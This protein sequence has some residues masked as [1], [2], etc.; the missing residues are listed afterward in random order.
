MAPTMLL[1]MESL[2]SLYDALVSINIPTD[3][4]RAVVDAV[5]RDMLNQLATKADLQFTGEL[6]SRDIQ[7]QTMVITVRLGSLMILGVG[8]LY[9]LIKLA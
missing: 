3:R 2:Y 1:D 7:H 6:L 8:A 5:E 9:T 4:A